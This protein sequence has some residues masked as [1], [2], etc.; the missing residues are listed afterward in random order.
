[1]EYDYEKDVLKILKML[2]YGVK[3][4]TYEYEDILKNATLTDPWTTVYLPV[5][6]IEE[7]GI[8]KHKI[9]KLFFGVCRKQGLAP[10]DFMDEHPEMVTDENG[11]ERVIDVHTIRTTDNN[12]FVAFPAVY[13]ISSVISDIQNNKEKTENPELITKH[14]DANNSITLDGLTGK[15]SYNKVTGIIT[16]RNLKLLRA[17]LKSKD[18]SV[19]YHEMSKMFFNADEYNKA[20]H[21]KGFSDTLNSLK[22]DLGILPK[23]D[24]SNPDCFENIALTSYRLI[25]PK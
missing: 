5:V 11:Y 14:F 18:N 21:S 20:K 2:E 4:F 17:L 13:W 6:E 7:V 12:K 25:S 22:N 9:D 3:R 8:S 1:M 23:T 15:F 19:S 10:Y 24:K 16:K